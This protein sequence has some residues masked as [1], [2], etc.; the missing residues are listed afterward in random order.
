MKKLIAAFNIL[1]LTFFSCSDTDNQPK[2][3]LWEWEKGFAI[4]SIE[5]EGIK[6]YFWF[7]EW[8]MFD[9]MEKGEHT[10]G[11]FENNRRLNEDSTFAQISTDNLKVEMTV[12]KNGVNLLLTVTNSTQHTWPDIAAIIPCFNPGAP[13]H[14]SEHYPLA[15]LNEQFNNTNTYFVGQARL[16]KLFKRQ[17]HFNDNLSHSLE[18]ISPTGEFVFSNKWPTATTTNH[19]I[20]IRESNDK[21][22]VTGIAWEN[23]LSVQGHNPWQCMHLGILVGPLGQGETK[24]V[25]GKIYLFEGTKEECYAKYVREFG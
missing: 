13:P 6:M 10:N 12:V 9:A 22:W 5:Q 24:T 3:K 18:Q 8:N 16:E 4:E 21:K 2:L 7:Y 17:I 11:S 1:V 23:F 15:K 19:G 20:L 14:R 25:R